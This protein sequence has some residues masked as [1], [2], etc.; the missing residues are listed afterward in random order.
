MQIFEEVEKS[1]EAS[2][3]KLS[4]ELKLCLAGNEWE[5][6]RRVAEVPTPCDRLYVTYSIRAKN[7]ENRS[8]EHAVQLMASTTEFLD[9]LST[10]KG[11]SCY[12]L[13]VKGNQEHQYVVAY[14]PSNRTLLGILKTVSQNDVSKDRWRELWGAP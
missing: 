7:L 9:N 14:E 3:L 12:L 11:E 13:T 2:S 5:I 6:V 10:N 1:I 8:S 4:A